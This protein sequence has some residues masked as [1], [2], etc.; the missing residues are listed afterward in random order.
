[1][2]LVSYDIHDNTLRLKVSKILLKSGL[3]RIQKSVFLGNLDGVKEEPVVKALENMALHQ[4]WQGTDSILWM[5]L[6]DYT[7][8]HTLTIGADLKDWDLIKGDLHTL[9]I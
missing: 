9:F 7:T 1:M 2:H 8:E 4:D 6:H 3:Y 5:P